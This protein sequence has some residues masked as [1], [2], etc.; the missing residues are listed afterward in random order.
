MKLPRISSLLFALAALAPGAAHAQDDDAP[1]VPPP[2]PAT[3]LPPDDAAADKP[4]APAEDPDVVAAREYERRAQELLD[5]RQLEQAVALWRKAEQRRPDVAHELGI[6]KAF[7]KMGKLL[8]ARALFRKVAEAPI[9]PTAVPSALGT[10]AAAVEGAKAIDARIAKIML[11]I[12]GQRGARFV[13]KLDGAAVDAA[14]LADKL[15][16]DP[17]AHTLEVSETGGSSVMRTVT[18]REAET[19]LV[20]VDLRPPPGFQARSLAPFS[21][22]LG[23]LGLGLGAVTGGLSLAK[24]SDVKSRCID[25]HCSP[26]D[27]PEADSARTLGTVST[28]GFI[29]GGV[30]AATGIVL[31]L[32]PHDRDDASKPDAPK[33][34]AWSL[35]IGPGAVLLG[36]GF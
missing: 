11:D 17:G 10:R 5:D 22:G 3:P 20:H 9:A 31:L 21:L 18:A 32:V 33:R 2:I 28:V 13:V 12:K 36:G 25:G 34:A 19:E 29:A 23:A 6:A 14:R 8:E 26:A 15:E 4:P 1:I 24:V 27:Q 16:V 30:L 35:G 7:A